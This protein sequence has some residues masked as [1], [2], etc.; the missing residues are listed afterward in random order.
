MIR[1]LHIRESYLYENAITNLRNYIDDNGMLLYIEKTLRN[2]YD[3]NIQTAKV[4]PIDKPKSV[5]AAQRTPDILIGID[6]KNQDVIICWRD[7][8]YGSRYHADMY[9]REVFKNCDK[10]FKVVPED[11]DT[12]I[13]RDEI[14]ADREKDKGAKYTSKATS[15]KIYDFERAL[16]DTEEATKRYIN[17]A[18]DLRTKRI[19]E[20]LYN[21]VITLNDRIRSID[22]GNPILDNT[23]KIDTLRKKYN[24][25]QYSIKDLNGYINKEYNPFNRDDTYFSSNAYRVVGICEDAVQDINKYL[26]DNF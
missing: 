17:K 19:Q 4:V 22:F 9:K 7:Y 26:D 2:N 14:R 18:R 23:S 3:I 15:K 13:K 20:K 11:E 16:Y 21:D 6:D 5:I 25:L 24:A 1:K 12:Y 8:W 10:W